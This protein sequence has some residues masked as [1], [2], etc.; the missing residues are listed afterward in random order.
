MLPAPR[1]R[2]PARHTSGSRGHRATGVL[3]IEGGLEVA[4]RQELAGLE[5]DALRDE[6]EKIRVRLNRF[7]SPF[8]SAVVFEMVD[9]IDPRDTRAVL[10]RWANLVAPTRKPGSMAWTFRP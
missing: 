1:T 3:P 8:R 10:T 9:V 2:F 6:V 5:G 7:R 4:Y